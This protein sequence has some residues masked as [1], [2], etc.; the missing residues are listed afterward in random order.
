[1]TKREYKGIELEGIRAERLPTTWG[2]AF[3][4]EFKDGGAYRV[5]HNSD[6]GEAF[7]FRARRPPTGPFGA[8]Y[9][10]VIATS[11]HKDPDEALAE[12]IEQLSTFEYE[13]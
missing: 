2:N 1:M 5:N 4:V 13:G 7:A 3:F 8:E 12:C 9:W 10:R 11:C 6:N